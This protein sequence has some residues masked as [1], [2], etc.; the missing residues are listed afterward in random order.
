M[1]DLELLTLNLVQMIIESIES[2]DST[3][4]PLL[5][6]D[7]SGSLFLTKTD[8]TTG[9]S[10]VVGCSFWETKY[11]KIYLTDYNLCWDEFSGGLEKA[12]LLKDKGIVTLFYKNKG[13]FIYEKISE[14]MLNDN[15]FMLKKIDIFYSRTQDYRQLQTNARFNA[16]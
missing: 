4:P 5:I 1:A 16:L 2:Q 3:N 14:C 7:V 8:I 13:V 11:D 9:V 10:F 6:A 12:N 15:D